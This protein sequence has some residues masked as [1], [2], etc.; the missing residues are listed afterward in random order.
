MH[1]LIFYNLNPIGY[2]YNRTALFSTR[3]RELASICSIKTTSESYA[4]P[5]ESYILPFGN[6]H[7]QIC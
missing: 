6:N 1:V 5:N 2:R 4:K 3:M 7:C